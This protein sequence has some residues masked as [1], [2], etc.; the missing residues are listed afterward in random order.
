MTIVW[1]QLPQEALCR[2]RFLRESSLPLGK[3][4]ELVKKLATDDCRYQVV[5]GAFV[6]LIWPLK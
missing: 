2:D 1:P 3:A 5:Q 6:L 4:E